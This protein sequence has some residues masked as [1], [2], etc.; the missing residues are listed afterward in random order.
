LCSQTGISSKRHKQGKVCY[1][2]HDEEVQVITLLRR[3][4]Y[5]VIEQGKTI[6][7]LKSHVEAL[8]SK[9]S[10]IGRLLIE[11]GDIRGLSQLRRIF[12]E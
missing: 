2:T 5:T 11:D 3:A 9:V 1:M 7:S 8:E 4:I 10:T 6:K 12:G